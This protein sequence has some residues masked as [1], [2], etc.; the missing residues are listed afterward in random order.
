MDLELK[1]KRALAEVDILV[2]NVGIFEPKPFEEIPDVDWLS[3]SRRAPTPPV[4]R[5]SSSDSPRRPRSR[6]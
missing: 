1:G 2:N 5:G 3:P 4:L 6:R